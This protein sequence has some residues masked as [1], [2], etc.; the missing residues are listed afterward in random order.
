MHKC[1]LYGSYGY[2]GRLIARLAAAEG[3][4]PIL[5]GRNA[6]K[7]RAHAEDLGLEHRVFALDDPDALDAGL[8]GIDVV[9]HCAGPF[10][11]TSQPMVEA[12]LRTRT[13]YLDITGEAGIF[14]ACARQNQAALH[15]GVMV[16]PGVGFDVVPTDCLANHLKERL[17][18]ATHLT[19][20]FK[21]VGGGVSHG[22]AMTMTEGLGE[23]NWIRKD[24]K[25]T[26]VRF[27]K[28]CKQVDFGRGPTPCLGIPWGDISTAYTSTGIP[29]IDIY[30]GVSSGAVRGAR[31]GG[32]FGGVLRSEFVKKRARKRIANAPAGP[33]DEVRARSFTM[34]WG[35]ARVGDD[36]VE[37]R[38][39]VPEG[40]TLTALT[41]WD[42]A[43]RCVAGEAKA[44][45]QTPA[46]A[47]G[48]DYILGFDGVEREDLN[49]QG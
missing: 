39:R 40:Y 14:E 19:M 30:T 9:L 10:I 1:L 5:A 11:H 21:S 38:L 16:M 8:E 29:N 47:F 25:L 15:A 33:S 34:I 6:D 42:I 36:V 37:T 32:Y 24:G 13:H 31:I 18:D 35:E 48:A 46:M 23:P 4:K 7:V 43:K 49:A 22:T 41:G 2:T 28:L 45:Y 27:G 3:Q 20:A 17:P 44:G 26:P 12:C